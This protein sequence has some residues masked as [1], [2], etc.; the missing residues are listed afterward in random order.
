MARTKKELSKASELMM[1]IRLNF[2][3]TLRIFTNEIQENE[4]A[5][6]YVKMVEEIVNDAA[7]KITK[8]LNEL[9]IYSR[10]NQMSDEQKK[11]LRTLL[12]E[13]GEN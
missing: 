1:S 2:N 8:M 9:S 6:E 4:R 11:I 7:G 5:E 10:F 3:K 13:E 12:E